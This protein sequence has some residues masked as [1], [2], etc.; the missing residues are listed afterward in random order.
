M[1]IHGNKEHPF[2]STVRPD[3]IYMRVV[4]L[5]R[6][7]KGL[8][9]LQ[10]FD[11]LISLLNIWKDF[12]VL[13]CFMQKWIQPPACSDQS[14]HRILSSYWLA[15]FYLM[16][17]SAKVLLYFGLVGRMLDSLLT[18]R[19]PRNNWCLSPIFGARLGGKDRS[20]STCKL[21]SKQAGGW[22]HFFMKRLRTL[23]SYQIF[24]VK[25]KK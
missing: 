3:Q 11:F 7:W 20:L 9:P 23:N 21:G 1:L 6:P 22:I 13:S 18:S 4:P 2:N 14:L 16:K 12:K 24:K 15:H 25:N 17:K 19:I 10:V 5:V 8:Q